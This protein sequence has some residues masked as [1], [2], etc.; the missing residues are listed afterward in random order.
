[1]VEALALVGVVPEMRVHPDLLAA[2]ASDPAAAAELMVSWSFGAGGLT[3]GNPA[4]GLFLPGT[5]RRLIQRTTAA[6]LAGDLTAC[7]TYRGATAAAA[8]IRCPTLLLLGARD[9]MTPPAQCKALA[10]LIAASRVIGLPDV[11]HSLMIEAPAATLAALAAA[12]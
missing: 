9:R 8:R 12:L 11:G 7:D 2:A 1:V 4:P 10:A 3:G 6:V 5:A